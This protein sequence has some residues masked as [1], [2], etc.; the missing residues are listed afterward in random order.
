MRKS[1][2][3]GELLVRKRLITRDQL[4]KALEQQRTTK[5]PLGRILLRLGF[6]QNEVQLKL[7]L[8]KQLDT[9]FLPA[10]LL[11]PKTDQRLKELVPRD[12]ALEQLILPLERTGNRLKLAIAKAPDIILIDNLRKITGCDIMPV[13]ATE[14]GLRQAID[15][16]YGKTELEEVISSSAIHEASELY[17]M[18]QQEVIN[19]ES[20]TIEADQAPVVKL[21]DVLLKK[22]AD[23]RASDIHIEPFQDQISIRYRIDGVLY[24][25]APPPRK[26]HLAMISRVKIL[27]R[28]DIAEKRIPQDG[29]FELQYQ[30][31]KIDVRVSTIPVVHGEKVVMRLLDKRPELLDLKA[32]GLHPDQLT[33]FEE[34]IQ[35]PYGLVFITGPTGSGKSTTLYAAINRRRSSKINILTIEDPVEY[36]ITGINQVQ[37]KPDIGLTFATGLRAFLRQDPDV[38]LVGEVRDQETAE[39]CIRAALTGHLVLSTLHTNDAAT[40]ISRLADIG[41][42]TYLIAGSLLL[43]GAQR[44]VRR[45]CQECK[46][47]YPVDEK[48][49]SDY[50]LT[51]DTIYRPKGCKKCRNIGYWGRVAIYEMLP[52]DEELRHIISA[53]GELGVIRELQKKRGH[54]TLLRSGLKKVEEGVTSLEEVLSVA[55][56]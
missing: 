33:V 44:L 9:P 4:N 8:S 21:I 47:G 46:E 14:A 10:E 48:A 54:V 7:A 43:V 3:I 34:A 6:V 26:F 1:I 22:A 41:V 35:K 36:Q 42:K 40:A 13:L 17:T 5:E 24:P 19:L 45:L 37:V 56:E 11:Q 38:I 39:I 55:Y 28:L 32:L 20:A 2:Q 51:V 30:G 25:L 49:R 18:D 29:A 31:R 27:S 23:D 53:G 12:M 15:R 50:Q 52:V 16:F